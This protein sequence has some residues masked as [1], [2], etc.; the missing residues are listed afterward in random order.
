MF[1]GLLRGNRE[2]AVLQ[3]GL[4]FI[5]LKSR[6]IDGELVTLVGL[7]NIGL[8]HAVGVTAEHRGCPKEVLVRKGIRGESREERIR[9]QLRKTIAHFL[10]PETH[11]GRT[12]RNLFDSLSFLVTPYIGAPRLSQQWYKSVLNEERFA[13]I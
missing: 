11:P 1:H 9:K 4:D 3:F 7:A 10:S 5:L 6:Q 2:V 13:P 12:F 8:H